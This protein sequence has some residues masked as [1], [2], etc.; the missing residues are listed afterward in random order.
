MGNISVSTNRTRS[1]SAKLFINVDESSIGRCQ[2]SDL[3]LTD[4][5]L[6]ITRE[7]YGLLK[8]QGENVVAEFFDK[9]R[10]LILRPCIIVGKYD[11]TNRFNLLLD[12]IKNSSSIEVPDDKDTFIQFIDVRSLA[13]FVL[14]K[15]SLSGIFNLIGH[16]Q[17]II[18]ILKSDNFTFQV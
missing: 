2:S 6:P 9:S 11:D 5:N 10:T 4:V 12:K 3:P 17:S 13:D 14:N 8:A 16:S 1:S 15:H 18:M 7:S